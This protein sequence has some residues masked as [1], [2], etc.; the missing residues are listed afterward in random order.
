MPT[1]HS[2]APDSPPLR[3]GDLCVT[4]A[5]SLPR[6]RVIAVHE[7]RVWVRDTETGTDAVVAQG[8]CKRALETGGHVADAPAAPE[9]PHRI[10][11]G[12]PMPADEH[13]PDGS[14]RP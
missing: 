5:N 14:P 2:P 13:W 4:G 8:H 10:R 7:D 9:R 11:E 1:A 12:A 3:P 6:F